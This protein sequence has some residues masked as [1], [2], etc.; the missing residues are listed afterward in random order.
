MRQALPPKVVAENIL[1]EIYDTI[2]SACMA[3]FDIDTYY[4]F[5]HSLRG[6]VADVVDLEECARAHIIFAEITQVPIILDGFGEAVMIESRIVGRPNL[7]AWDGASEEDGVDSIG[8]QIVRTFVK[9]KNHKSSVSI[10]VP[11]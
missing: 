3:A 6:L 9:C 10:E 5:E 11:V 1:D 7:G 4:D 2:F 8:C